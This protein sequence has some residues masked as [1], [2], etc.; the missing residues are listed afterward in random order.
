MKGFS[1]K[2]LSLKADVI[3]A[4]NV[5]FENVL[6]ENVLFENVLFQKK[7]KKNVLFAGVS[8]HLSARKFYRLAQ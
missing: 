8:V 4:E 1:S 3:G 2:R 7:I 5:L 6:F